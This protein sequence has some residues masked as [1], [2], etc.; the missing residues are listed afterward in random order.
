MDRNTMKV[1]EERNNTV[2]H[3]FVGAALRGRPSSRRP[4]ICEG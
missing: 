4:S 2:K 1:F 3:Q